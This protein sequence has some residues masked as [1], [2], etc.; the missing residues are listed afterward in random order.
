MKRDSYS[1]G[2]TYVSPSTLSKTTIPVNNGA[3][4]IEYTIANGDAILNIANS[5]FSSIIDTSINNTVIFDAS[6]VTNATSVVIPASAL[7]SISEKNLA[8]TVILLNGTVAF[9]KTSIA[10][11]VAA[12]TGTTIS[13]VVQDARSKLNDKQKKT[14]SDST[15]YDISVISNSVRITSFGDGILTVSIPYTLPTGVKATQVVPYSLKDDGSIELVSGKY[16]AMN[17]KM[18]LKLSH[19]SKYVLKTNRVTYSVE[20]GWNDADSF[21]F[22]VQRGLFDKF[23][24]DG[25]ITASDT[26]SREDFIVSL[27]KAMGIQPMTEFTVEQ[28]ADVNSANSAYLRT[29]REL[30]VI[31]GVENNKFEPERAATRGEEFQVIYNLINSGLISLDTVATNGKKID[32]FGDA[33]DIPTWL[34]PALAYLLEMGIIV[35]DGLNLNVNDDFT[36][37]ETAVLVMR[38]S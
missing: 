15:I 9:S 2:N 20:S 14:V 33:A 19:L 24:K 28:F 38:L 13:V 21:D 8:V 12:A 17:K 31:A 6:K 26:I 37:G 22:T 34:K 3:I 16:D 36:L 29:A 4:D 18:V 7:K 11:V 30:G 32:D 1:G 25:K 35:G 23:L 5:N 27:M 10:A